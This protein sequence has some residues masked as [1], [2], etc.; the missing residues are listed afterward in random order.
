MKKVICSVLVLVL[1]GVWLTRSN[2]EGRSYTVRNDGITNIYLVDDNNN[3][4]S[5]P[6][7]LGNS[8]LKYIRELT[9]VAE[10][11]TSVSN[12]INIHVVD[13]VGDLWYFSGKWTDSGDLHKEE[14]LNDTRYV[15]SVRDTVY[16]IKEDGSLWAWG[17]NAYGQV[18]VGKAFNNKIDNYIESPV[19]VMD[20]IKEIVAPGNYYNTYVI[21]NDN[22]LWGWGY[23]WYSQMATYTDRHVLQPKKILENVNFVVTNGATVYAVDLDGSLWVWGNNQ[24]GQVGNGERGNIVHKPTKVLENV[25]D[26][27][28]EKWSAYALKSDGTMWSWSQN[29]TG[30]DYSEIEKGYYPVQILDN[31]H[32]FV[33]NGDGRYALDNEGDLFGWGEAVGI[34]VNNLSVDRVYTPT[35]IAENVSNVYANH[36][37]AFIVKEDGTSLTWVVNKEENTFDL[38]EVLDNVEEITMIGGLPIYTKKDGTVWMFEQKINDEIVIKQVFVGVTPSNIVERSDSNVTY[39]NYKDSI[40]KFK[41]KFYSS[42]IIIGILVLYWIKSFIKHKE[43]KDVEKLLTEWREENEDRRN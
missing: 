35:K 38:V 5:E 6:I 22:T 3:L 20:D 42:A 23:N 13:E 16:A 25:V 7:T 30:Q 33:I 17:D 8:G 36:K 31:I 12:G 1:I 18:G 29:Y 14:I 39:E 4:W 32:S 27:Q 37:R 10:N 34:Y 43:E 26:V 40:I 2:Y 11:I 41:G 15:T 19:K 9:M 21:K 24:S 28:I